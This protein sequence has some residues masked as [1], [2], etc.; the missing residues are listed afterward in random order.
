MRTAI[1][2]SGH[3]VRFVSAAVTAAISPP[4]ETVAVIERLV[5]FERLRWMRCGSCGH[6]WH[7]DS[8]W[9]WHFEQGDEACP[10]CGTNYEPLDRPDFWASPDDPSHDDAKVRGSFWYHTSAHSN[11]PDRAFDPTAGLTEVTKRRFH[12]SW[13]D[14]HGLERWASN[15]KT[16]ALHLGTY[17]AAIENMLRRMHE[18]DCAGD[19]FYLYRVRLNQDAVIQPGVHKELPGFFGDVQLAEHC[20]QDIDIFR[21]VNTYEDPSGIS[22]AVTL[23][24][25]TTVQMVAIPLVID[26]DD[27]WVS[28]AAARLVDAASRPAPEPT[29]NLERMQRRR[30]SA[31]SLEA[32][33]LEEEIAL[34]LPLGL[35]DGFERLFDE[36][37][38]TAE[39]TAF[40]AKLVG[41]A[42]LINEPLTV[43]ELLDTAPWREV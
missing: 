18:Q 27:T 43:L 32:S 20:A 10:T 33:R 36:R 4:C 19:Q 24:A 42:Q 14:G 1:G 28:A 23:E 37:N 40:P 26:S 25:I 3:T 15:Q 39:P 30:P 41:L 21:Y 17:E 8:E 16:K 6:E 11:W 13:G 5:D 9:L 34:R 2:F 22:L 12:R 35:R 31:L 38:L 7:V 29:T